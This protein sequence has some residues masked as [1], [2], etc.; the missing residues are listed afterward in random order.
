MCCPPCMKTS[1]PNEKFCKTFV[2]EK[3]IADFIKL[4]TFLE[5]NILEVKLMILD[6]KKTKKSKKIC[7]STFGLL[8]H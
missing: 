6:L 8:V 1:K 2:S 5:R 7:Q 3:T 4:K